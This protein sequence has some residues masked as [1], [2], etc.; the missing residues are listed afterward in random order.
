MI[1]CPACCST[2][3]KKN[4]FTHY[5]KQNHKCKSCNRQFVLDSQIVTEEKRT[6][7]KRLLLERISLRGIC[8]V[9][10]I[11]MSWLM[12]FVSAFYES[13]DDDLYVA[14]PEEA[15]NEGGRIL[16]RCFTCEADEQWSFVGSKANQ[17]WLWVAFDLETRQ[18]VAFHVGAREDREAMRLWLKLPKRYRLQATMHTDG[19]A[20]YERVIPA[21]LH[22]PS[23][24]EGKTNHVERFFGTLRQ[25]LSRLVRK[26]L[27]FSKKWAHHV[28]AIQHFLCYYNQQIAPRLA[29]A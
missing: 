16:V 13:L 9:L 15:R 26:T 7:V 19:L 29:A 20:A 11:S 21:Y 17:A 3:I 28:G 12:T 27:S 23:R 6:L 8:R 24:G 25:R 18:V 10:E 4:G 2:D 1:Q 22:E 5:G 14:W